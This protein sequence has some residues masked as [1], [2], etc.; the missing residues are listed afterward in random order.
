MRPRFPV[1]T[2]C[3]AWL[4]LVG[5]PSL[6]RGQCQV[7]V[8]PNRAALPWRQAS[9]EAMQHIESLPTETRD[10]R[11]VSVEVREHGALVTMT[12]RDGRLAQRPILRPEDLTPTLSALMTTVAVSSGEASHREDRPLRATAVVKVPPAGDADQ[13]AS[14]APRPHGGHVVIAGAVGA[15]WGAPN[16]LL[17]S[18]VQVAAGVSLAHWE[19]GVFAEVEPVH[20]SSFNVPGGFKMW[21]A[22]AG[23]AAGV[24]L[25]TGPLALAGGARLGAGIVSET[26][27]SQGDAQD[28]AGDQNG[29]IGGAV[30]EPLAGLYGGVVWPSRNRLRARS[31][32]LLDATPTRLGATRTVDAALPPLP[33]W[34]VTIQLGVEGDVL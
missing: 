3:A 22:C 12:T 15:R 4:A 13:D 18:V 9:V 20:S 10:C 8:H 17:G 29:S 1:Q 33:A 6:A 28:A 24:R 32:L 26:A 5:W 11:D 19:L 31:L 27:T 7:T 30:A 34:S 16:Q 25:P 2:V 23:I 14:N 21:S